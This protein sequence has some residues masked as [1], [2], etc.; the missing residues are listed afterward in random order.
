MHKL[1]QLYTNCAREVRPLIAHCMALSSEQGLAS[2]LKIL[3][4]RFG[5]E[6]VYMH[7]ARER[8][9]RGPTISE[10][11]YQALS[12]MC[13]Q[14]TSYISFAENI[15]QLSDIDNTPTIRDILLRLDRAM[16]T[17]WNSRW[18]GKRGSRPQR[19]TDVLHFMKKETKRVENN[20]LLTERHGAELRKLSGGETDNGKEAADKQGKASGARREAKVPVFVTQGSTR[21]RMEGGR[22]GN[23][24]CRLCGDLHALSSCTIFR[25]IPVEHRKRVVRAQGKCFLCLRDSHLVRDCRAQLCEIENC[26]GRHSKWLHETAAGARPRRGGATPGQRVSAEVSRGASGN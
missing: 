5:D 16:Q 21:G 8:L 23:D 26:R 18:T 20:L 10:N 14:L 6:R 3:D 24:G 1:N 7:H 11:D 2:A 25:L 19:I 4:E 22:F 17:R 13:S 12:Q 9:I 15:G